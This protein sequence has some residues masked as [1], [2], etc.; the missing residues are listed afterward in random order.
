MAAIDHGRFDHKK[1]DARFEDRRRLR[2]CL[3]DAQQKGSGENGFHHE[4]TPRE[5]YVTLTSECT[6]RL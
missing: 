5:Y 3:R 2:S 4:S 6:D 1:I